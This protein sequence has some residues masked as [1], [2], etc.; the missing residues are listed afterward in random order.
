MSFP[1][2]VVSGADAESSRE[3]VAVW[4]HPRRSRH[5]VI[6]NQ[7][8]LNFFDSL[9]LHINSRPLWVWLPFA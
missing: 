8:N 1:P 7:E 2:P 4:P 3:V 6:F 9:K 5:V